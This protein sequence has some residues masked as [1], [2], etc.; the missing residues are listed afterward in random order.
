[1]KLERTN[2]YQFYLQKKLC[3]GLIPVVADYF[4]DR[5]NDR[6]RIILAK[7]SFPQTVIP[8]TSKL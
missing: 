7:K 4:C 2:H 6:Q 3:Q 5:K 1:M 8:P